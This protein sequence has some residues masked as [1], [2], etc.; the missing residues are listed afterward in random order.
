MALPLSPDVAVLTVEALLAQATLTALV[1]DRIYTGWPEFQQW[2]L[3]TVD[4]VDAAEDDASCTVA[5]V[6]VNC[7]GQGLSPDD[8]RESNLIARTIQS[9]SRDLRGAWPHGHIVNSAPLNVVPAPDNGWW[10]Y[11]IDL[12]LEVYP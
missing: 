2:P 11:T 5:R 6:Q 8:E 3:C 4:L 1:G 10:R 7:W 12:E 9:V